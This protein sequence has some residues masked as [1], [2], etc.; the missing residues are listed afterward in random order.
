MARLA[1]LNFYAGIAG[2]GPR[3]GSIIPLD[4]EVN[5][6]MRHSPKCTAKG[7]PEKAKQIIYIADKP[8]P[9]CDAHAAAWKEYEA[10]LKAFN[11]IRKGG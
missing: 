8:V 4:E 10:G 5:A 7:C 2:H 11:L 3:G 9:Y 6:I 1:V